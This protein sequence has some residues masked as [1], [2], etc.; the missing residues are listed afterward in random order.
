MTAKTLA[1][2]PRRARF[3]RTRLLPVTLLLPGILVILFV[4]AFP[5]LYSLYLSFTNYNLDQCPQLHFVGL[6]NYITLFE[7]PTSGRRSGAPY[8]S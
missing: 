7:D 6:G 1:R 5:M 4:V 2:P 8:S 3:P